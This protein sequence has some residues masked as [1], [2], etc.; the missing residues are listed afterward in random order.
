[1][2]LIQGWKI[3]F[4][5][6]ADP[7]ER[8][9]LASDPD[10]AADVTRLLAALDATPVYP[11]PSCRDKCKVNSLLDSSTGLY[12]FGCCEN[13]DFEAAMANGCDGHVWDDED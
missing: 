13:Y 8:T 6:P 1:M 9:N 2:R 12:I 7:E 3:F 11:F 4:F 5:L 10:H